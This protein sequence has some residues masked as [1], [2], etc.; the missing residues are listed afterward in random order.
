M[1]NLTEN[2]LNQQSFVGHMA[3]YAL[4]IVILYVPTKSFFLFY[5]VLTTTAIAYF[6]A[7]G[8]SRSFATYFLSL[9][10]VGLA[11]AVFASR[12]IIF[13]NIDDGKE[14]VKLIVFFLTI[15]SSISASDKKTD[16]IF[17]GFVISN[18]AFSLLQFFHID[19][20]G[21]PWLSNIYNADKH[22]EASLSYSIPR[23]LGYSS[24]PAQQ[25]AISLLLFSYFLTAILW[26]RNTILRLGCLLCSIST[27]L[28]TQSKSVLIAL[29][30]ALLIVLFLK[31]KNQR[32]TAKAIS[33]SLA[34]LIFTAFVFNFNEITR[35]LPELARLSDG[36]FGV[37]SFQ[38]RLFN[39]SLM[40]D[41][42]IRMDSYFM[43][44]FGVGRSGL[45]AFNLADV[46]FDSDYMY[47]YVM[48][49][50]LGGGAIILLLIAFFL[51]KLFQFKSLNT[52]EKFL[53]VFTI[54]AIT[55][56]T[57]FN[58]VFDPR[59]FALLGVFSSMV[60]HEKWL[61]SYRA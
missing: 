49:G 56:A 47:L 39:W 20:F 34:L 58:I 55:P 36:I 11:T 38:D 33:F 54:F 16:N 42:F 43:Y 25:A 10:I 17:A 30:P 2:K 46:P 29:P 50:L 18:F 15:N 60:R 21:V 32:F 13:Q 26:R 48:F 27:L 7:N 9:I 40:N 24:G 4:F 52:R 14:I 28:L 61:H 35:L 3:T 5:G 41:V 1:K 23:A 53:V 6:F 57:S 59:V 37:S 12:I 19:R 8:P 51:R 45:G 44:V 22:I 31:L